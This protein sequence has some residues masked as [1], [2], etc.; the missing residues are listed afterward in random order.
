[1]NYKTLRQQLRGLAAADFGM[2]E[3][4]WEQ[5]YAKLLAPQFK[6]TEK[7]M[8]TLLRLTKQRHVEHEAR[9]QGPD[10]DWAGW[11]AE[12]MMD[13][14]CIQTGQACQTGGAE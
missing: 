1:M 10:P 8:T 14:M 9:L 6:L 2:N 11:Y 4:G 3:E 13:Y 7:E 5:R 12:F